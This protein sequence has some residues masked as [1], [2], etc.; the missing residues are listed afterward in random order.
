MAEVLR[1]V[2]TVTENDLSTILWSLAERAHRTADH[3]L[4]VFHTRRLQ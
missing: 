1:Y 4:D 3:M 2:I